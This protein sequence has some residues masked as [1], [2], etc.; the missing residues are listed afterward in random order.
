MQVIP[1]LRPSAVQASSY[2]SHAGLCGAG[3]QLQAFGVTLTSSFEN[4]F[5]TA[6]NEVAVITVSNAL[7]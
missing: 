3:R 6:S 4:L 1:I 2:L 5:L 7:R